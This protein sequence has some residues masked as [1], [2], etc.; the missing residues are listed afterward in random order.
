[1]HH[2]VTL[3]PSWS[4]LCDKAG[5]AFEWTG[6]PQPSCLGWPGRVCTFRIWSPLKRPIIR[7][8][9]KFQH[10]PLTHSNGPL[11]K[12]P[13]RNFQSYDKSMSLKMTEAQ[14]FMLH[15]SHGQTPRSLRNGLICFSRLLFKRAQAAFWFLLETQQKSYKH[16]VPTLR[17]E[18][19]IQFSLHDSIAPAFPAWCRLFLGLE[20]VEADVW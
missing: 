17:D 1:M 20:T 10:D 19:I 4:A 12:K 3:L 6:T 5:T 13:L 18:L 2:V 16:S 15:K 8:L 14:C 11:K 9:E 7:L